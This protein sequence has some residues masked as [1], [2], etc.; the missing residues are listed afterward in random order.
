LD[1]P[2]IGGTSRRRRVIRLVLV[3]ALAGAMS[4]AV[5]SVRTPVLIQLGRQLVSQDPVVAADVIVIGPDAGEAGVLEAADLVREGVAPRVTV[6]AEPL[7]PIAEEF[8]RRG[9]GYQD[10]GGR[11]A[12][13]LRQ[14]G[15]ERVDVVRLAVGGTEEAG[16]I[17]PELCARQN[18]RTVVMVTGA[19]HSRRFRRVLHRSMR[20]ASATVVVRPSRYSGFVA[21]RWWQDRASLRR[22]IVELQK[23]VLDAIRHP[24]S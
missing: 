16:R 14:L 3:V 10:S 7:T 13:L 12:G 4:L 18:V 6:L 15:V 1:R 23:L 2:K 9:V 20:G 17:V 19:D 22:G 5:P 11:M 24:L 8:R 21:E